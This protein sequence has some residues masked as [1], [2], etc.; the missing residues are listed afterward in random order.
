MPW[1]AEDADRHNGGLSD[2]QKRQWAAVAN[3][4]LAKCEKEGGKDCEGSAIRQANAAVV[5]ESVRHAYDELIREAGRRRSDPRVTAAIEGYVSRSEGSLDEARECLELALQQEVVKVEDG[6][7]YPAAAYAYT[8]SPETPSAWKLRLR[9]GSDVTRGQLAKAAAALSPGGYRGRREDVP[10]A[11]LPAVKRRIRDAYRSLGVAETEIPRWVQEEQMRT[12]CSEYMPL[13]EAT[14]S[15][16]RAT[17]TVLKP[18]FTVTKQRY[19]PAETLARDYGVFEGVKMY[20]D[21]PTLDQERARP[22]GS[23]RDWV[24]TLQNVRVG[25]GGAI[26]GEA[27]VVEPWLQGKLALLREQGLLSE[28]GNSIRA[29]GIGSAAEVEGV[30]TLVIERITRAR[31]VD[32]VTE[33]G[34]GGGVMLYES[35]TADNDVDLVSLTDLQERRPD[36][37]KL[38]EADIKYQT[39]KEAKMDTE[40]KRVGELEGQIQTLTAERD[41]LRQQMDEAAKARKV[42]EAQAAIKEAVGKA[43]LPE[44]AKVRLL[45]KYAVAESADGLEQ[46]IKSEAEYI[47]RLTEAGKPRDMG[48]PGA[49]QPDRDSLADS[50]RRM[51]PE[52]TDAQINTAID[53]R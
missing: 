9:E 28:M 48:R 5:R 40:D 53:G 23:I 19:Y 43:T 4:A 29:V 14:F 10:K 21:H 52:W 12:I 30:K 15:R 36:L 1:S 47:A 50:W 49:G 38:I 25:S 45:E 2:E 16:G 20:A 33:P 41:T 35:A 18:G 46:A 26:V 6:V 11:D 13:T 17:I 44:P 31:S 8:P 24:A 32:F 42:A 34:A 22:E 51:H 7:S 37:I 3:A 27:V 39:Q